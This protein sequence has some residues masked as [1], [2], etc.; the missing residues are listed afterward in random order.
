M[1]ACLRLR[2]E[3]LASEMAGR[4]T[5]VENLS[6]LMRLTMKFALVLYARRK[7]ALPAS[8]GSWYRIPPGFG[9]LRRALGSTWH[10][11][12]RHF[13]P[14]LPGRPT[15]RLSLCR[16]PLLSFPATTKRCVSTCAGFATSRASMKTCSSC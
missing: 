1:D 3:Q 13:F 16:E 5:T 8:S 7:P 9:R 10:A 2:A 6:G 14:N 11:W 12:R 4:A 15:D